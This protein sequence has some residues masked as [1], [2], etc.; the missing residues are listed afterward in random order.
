MNTQM[1]D[2]YTDYLITQNHQAT[3]TGLAALLEN[4]I[5]HDQVTRFLHSADFGAKDLWLQIKSNVRASEEKT[6]GVLIIDDTIEEKDYTDENDIVCWHYSHAKSRHIKGMNIIT[7]MARYNDISFPIGYDVV[8]KDIP[9]SDLATKKQKRRA[10]VTKNEMFQNMLRQAWQNKVLF[11]YVL[12][13]NWFGSKDNMSFIHDDLKKHFIIGIKSN[14]TVALSRTEGKNSQFQ[15]VKSLNMKDG[16]SRKVWL[17]SL[18]FPVLLLKK[19]FTNE[20]GSKGTLYLV[21]SDISLGNGHIY[22][23]YQKRWRI[24]EFHKSIKQNASLAKSPTRKI[25]SQLN[26]IFASMMA[27]CKL[28]TLKIKTSMNHFAIRYK[29][30]VRANQIAFQ[31]IA[32]LKLALPAGA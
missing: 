26:H 16:E 22:D 28:E 18:S 19:V 32:K 4:E 27:Y 11:D 17:K 5:S 23:I 8:K 14:R 10:S 3:A 7:C 15:Q 1:L 9:F 6:G 29:L 2:I 25:R 12:A 13:D 21:T 24:E 31:E 30:I 20:N